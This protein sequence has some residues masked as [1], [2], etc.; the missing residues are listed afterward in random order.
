[1]LLLMQIYFKVAVLK[2][3]DEKLVW[4]PESSLPQSL[5]NEFETDT[6][7]SSSSFTNV[8][9]PGP[10]CEPPQK[11]QKLDTPNIEK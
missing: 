10:A 6:M 8:I 5:I 11:V 1:M 2:G 7:Q 9:N 3:D 4:V